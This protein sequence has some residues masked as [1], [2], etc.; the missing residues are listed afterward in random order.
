ME[1]RV[2]RTQ[3]A[4]RWLLGLVAS[5]LLMYMS[6]LSLQEDFT[7]QTPVIAGMLALVVVLM[8]GAKTLEGLIDSWK[9]GGSGNG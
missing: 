3:D 7:L 1:A 6:Y 5:G 2:P 4:V 9:G 8:F